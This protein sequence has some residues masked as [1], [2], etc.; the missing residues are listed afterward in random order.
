MLLEW[1]MVGLELFE[2]AHVDSFSMTITQS[3]SIEVKIEK[4][5]VMPRILSPSI[6]SLEMWAPLLFPFSFSRLSS[7][8]LSFCL[9]PPEFRVFGTSESFLFSLFALWNPGFLRSWSAPRP[10]VPCLLFDFEISGFRN[11]KV[12]SSFSLNALGLQ[13]PKTPKYS[14]HLFGFWNSRILESRCH[15]VGFSFFT[16]RFQDLKSP[17]SFCSCFLVFFQSFITPEFWGHLLSDLGTLRFW[18]PKVCVGSHSLSGVKI[19][20]Q[21]PLKLIYVLLSF[22][23][24]SPLGNPASPTSCFASFLPPSP[25]RSLF[26]CFCCFL[27]VLHVACVF[28]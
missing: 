23:L 2:V 9:A 25:G 14:P 5:S 8:S 17:R 21:G 16:S 10:F 12:S 26:V 19:A 20:L 13:N 4:D 11:L 28:S 22:K 6:S 18:N 1:R 24:F 15:V 7:L 3:H 27:F